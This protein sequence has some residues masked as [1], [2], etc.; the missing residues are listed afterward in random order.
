MA[1]PSEEARVECKVAADGACTPCGEQD[2]DQSYCRKNGWKQQLRCLEMRAGANQTY[3]EAETTS[4]YT[5][6]ACPVTFDGFVKFEARRRPTAA[7]SLC[8]SRLSLECACTCAQLLMMLCFALSFYYVQ[9]R[10]R[11]L[12]AIQ[13]WRIASY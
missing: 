6:E 7:H 11:R 3:L 8:R 1:R 10:K 2:Q 5:F 4:Y 12:L 13:Q 9:R